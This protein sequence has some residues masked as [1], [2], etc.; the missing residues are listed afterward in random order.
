[1]DLIFHF[2]KNMDDNSH[3]S[4]DA[5]MINTPTFAFTQDDLDL[6]DLHDED[7]LVEIP[8]DIQCETSV[9]D[10]HHEPSF[11]E[12]DF[13][14]EVLTVTVDPNDYEVSS[15]EEDNNL[16]QEHSKPI[17]PE[18]QS[19]I[20]VD[21]ADTA[22]PKARVL[23]GVRTNF[24][25]DSKKKAKKLI[26]RDILE[27]ID[28]Y[29]NDDAMSD[30]TSTALDATFD[31]VSSFNPVSTSARNLRSDLASPNIKKKHGFV[32]KKKIVAPTSTATSSMPMDT[33]PPTYA[34]MAVKKLSPGLASASAIYG[35]PSTDQDTAIF[36]DLNN[37]NLE[38]IKVSDLIPRVEDPGNE[39]TERHFFSNTGS[40]GDIWDKERD[41]LDPPRD[42]HHFRTPHVSKFADV[43]QFLESKF[44]RSLPVPERRVVQERSNYSSLSKPTSSTLTV[45]PSSRNLKR[46]T[47]E[48]RS[49]STRSR[50]D[51]RHHHHSKTKSCEKTEEERQRAGRRRHERAKAQTRT[52]LANLS[53][54]PNRNPKK[55]MPLPYEITLDAYAHF[56]IDKVGHNKFWRSVY[57]REKMAR[58]FSE[59]HSYTTAPNY[60]PVLTLRRAREM[61][62]QTFFVNPIPQQT[63]FEYKAGTTPIDPVLDEFLREIHEAK[64]CSFDTEG[65]G[66]FPGKQGPRLVVTFSSPLTGT[67]MI[68]HDHR[69]VP[70]ALRDILQD[71]AIAKL[72]S[73]IGS[74][75][76]LMSTFGFDVRGLL[77]SGTLLLLINPRIFF[78]AKHQL[79]EIYPDRPCHVPYHWK[80]MPIDFKKQDLTDETLRHVVQDVMTPFAVLFSAAIK[81]ADY[82]SYD[83]DRDVFPIINEALELCYSKQPD[84]VRQHGFKRPQDY[85]YPAVEASEFDL[86]SRSECQ[87][88]RRARG[89]LV[90]RHPTG[91][92]PYE[93][94][95]EA[96]KI[97]EA[98]DVPAPHSKILRGMNLY[99]LMS[100]L[101]QICGSDTHGIQE[102]DKTFVACPVHHYRGINHPPHSVLMCPQLHAHC[103]LCKVRGHTEMQHDLCQLRSPRQL[104]QDFLRYSH[105]GLYT[106]IP[107]L[108]RIDK[109]ESEANHGSYPRVKANHF[110]LSYSASTITRNQCD[111]WMYLGLDAFVPEEYMQTHEDRR[112]SVNDNF[113]STPETYIKMAGSTHVDYRDK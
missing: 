8:T 50:S 51:S 53:H 15:E 39:A 85:W 56:E 34:S 111:V 75:I 42:D 98:R 95:V 113:Y 69:D 64:F 32:V 106:S 49:D 10:F 17:S 5:D 71:Y 47:S 80:N 46:D 68:F 94:Y 48:R 104:R 28:A 19:N 24:K 108:Y 4:S 66:N 79:P 101:C 86:N 52:L 57:H 62:N 40:K 100:K 54:L 36:G 25:N 91:F 82:L 26:D 105:L 44:K 107:Y 103:P 88:I 27:Q 73:G 59:Y 3:T 89:H 92:S 18:T 37:L 70:S 72:Q 74:D 14:T 97:W 33:L 77:D 112:Q 110:R 61:V 76:T 87:L 81:R 45:R 67:V 31:S 9:P 58:E 6:L 11:D 102:C 1:M 22:D 29:V 109:D 60:M 96:F 38:P 99:L 84:D 7:Y 78:G 83:R 35:G 21:N 63:V 65:S 20:A 55:P 41:Q 16:E 93:L 90:E 2:R 13:D 43:R 30:V 12:F 23:D